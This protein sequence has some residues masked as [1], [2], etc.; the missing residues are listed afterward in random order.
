MGRR[1]KEL[2]N[3]SPQFLL[4]KCEYFALPVAEQT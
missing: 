3:K 1:Q 4:I 2:D